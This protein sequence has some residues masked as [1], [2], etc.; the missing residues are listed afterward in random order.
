ALPICAALGGGAQGQRDECADRR[1]E[2]RGVELLGRRLVGA[3]GPSGAEP[4]REILRRAVARPGE[5][6]DLAALVAGDLR[7]DV[8]GRAEAVDA[9]APRVAGHAQ[10]AIAELGRAS[11]R[12]G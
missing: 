5:G 11:C 1:E 2:E 4:S 7:D 12:E 3:A 6:V 9:D 8:R 10:R